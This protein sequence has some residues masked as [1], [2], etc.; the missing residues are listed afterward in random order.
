MDDNFVVMSS[1]H[2]DNFRVFYN[3][4][5]NII[6]VTI[7]LFKGILFFKPYKWNYWIISCIFDEKYF[8]KHV[9]SLLY[10]YMKNNL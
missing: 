2:D 5:L 6:F 9:I 1:L 4:I 10:I 3:K 8:L 7:I